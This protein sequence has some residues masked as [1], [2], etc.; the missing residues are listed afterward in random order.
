[1]AHDGPRASQLFLSFLSGKRKT[2]KSHDISS[3]LTK[4]ILNK[5]LHGFVQERAQ[6]LEELV[7]PML[8]CFLLARNTYTISQDNDA[9]RTAIIIIHSA[10]K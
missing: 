3:T 5:Y 10:F 1:M 8:L 6:R 2:Q 7:W 9:E 4:V